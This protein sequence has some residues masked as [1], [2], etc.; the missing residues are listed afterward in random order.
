MIHPSRQYTMKTG[1]QL[2]IKREYPLRHEISSIEKG[3]GYIL[4][5]HYK[6]FIADYKQGEDGLNMEREYR[7]DINYNDITGP[8][9][10]SMGLKKEIIVDY[11]YE[12]EEL[13]RTWQSI[14]QFE[15]TGERGLIKIAALGSDP[16]GGLYV[17]MVNNNKDEIWRVNWD[18]DNEEVFEKV[19]N[20]I[21]YFIDGLKQG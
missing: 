9:I 8:A 11:F 1:R 17:G 3:I 10:Y 12:A 19:T 13:V 18:M 5:S 20:S 4:P 2:L 21:W 14:D 6:D 7:E 16:N 15:E